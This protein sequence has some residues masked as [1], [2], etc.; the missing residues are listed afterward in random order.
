M[1]EIKRVLKPGGLVGL[2]FDYDSKRD[3]PGLDKGIR[4]S[5]KDRLTGDIIGPSGLAVYGN[6][7][8]TDDCPGDFFLGS[9]FLT[10]GESHEK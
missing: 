1:R 5:L 10:K 3:T 2:T 9:L 8:L 4:Y 6:E 7:K